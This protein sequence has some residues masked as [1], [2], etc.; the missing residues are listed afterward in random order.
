MEQVNPILLA[1]LHGV[2]AVFHVGGELHID[3]IPEALHHQACDHL[4]QGRGHQVLVLFHHILPVLNGGDGSGI[5][6]RTAHALFLHGLYQAGLGKPGRGLGEVLLLVELG[7]QGLL[8]HLQIRQRGAV[9]LRLV[10]PALLIDGNEAGEAKAL[11][12]GAE[13]VACAR[14]IDGHGIV[15]RIGHLACQEAAPNQLIQPVL[16]RRQAAAY[17]LRIQLHMGGTDGL[18]GILGTGLGFIHM[19]GAV[20]IVLPI[21]AADKIGGG[22]H[23][24]VGKPQGVGTHVGNQAQGTLALHV[25]ALIELLGNHHGPLGGHA[26]LAGGLLLQGGGG[27]GRRCRALLLRFFHI[28]NHKGAVLH[29]VD[30]GLG[31]GFVFQLPLFLLAV[32]VGHKAAGLSLAV[33]GHVQGPILPGLECTDF[34]FPVHHHPGGHGLDTSGGKAP[35]HLLP[36]QRGELVADNPVQNPPGLLGIHQVIVDIPGVLDGLPHHPLGNFIKGDPVGL[37]VREIQQLLQMPG[38]GLPLPVR[39]RCQIDGLHPCGIL[40]QF[41]DQLF[42]APDRDVVRLKVM[43]QIHAHFALGQVPQM[44]HAGLYQIV[45]AQVFSNGLRLGGRLHND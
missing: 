10:V 33:Q 15:H 34:I 17:P 19:E 9:G 35:A 12:G 29:I 1:L 30:D 45:R 31:L 40:L 27:E 28:G 32:I 41:L 18:V 39:V 22:G 26:Q 44:A 37:L 43:L 3:D 23:G 14:R 8:I 7:G 42:L 24:L 2:Q 20:V 36:K 11:V 38:D 13:G 25:H 16:V 4:A 5:G 21:A 6:G